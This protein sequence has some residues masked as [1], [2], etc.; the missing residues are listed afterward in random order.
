M[1]DHFHRLQAACLLALSILLTA[2]LLTGCEEGPVATR[3]PRPTFPPA[4]ATAAPTARPGSAS[5]TPADAEILLVGNTGGDGVYLRRTPSMADRVKAWPDGTRMKIIGRDQS[6]E[7][8]T[9][10]HVI[11]PD[12][13]TGFIP[14]EYLVP[15]GPAPAP[16]Q[17]P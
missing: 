4:T 17:R 8:K 10:K 1:S 6:G 9:W 7:G 13:T 14:I 5:A 12:G 16:T 11:D 15:T 3:T 2:I